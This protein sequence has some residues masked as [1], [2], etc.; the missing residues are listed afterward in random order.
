VTIIVGNDHNKYVNK[1]LLLE[2]TA[3]KQANLFHERDFTSSSI[4]QY[5]FLHRCT[6]IFTHSVFVYKVLSPKLSS[7][8]REG[9]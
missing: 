2:S 9:L 5:S 1:L 4:E 8:N 6:L 7:G 3:Y